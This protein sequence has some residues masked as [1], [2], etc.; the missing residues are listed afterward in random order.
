[1]LL[2][3]TAAAPLLQAMQQPGGATLLATA[4]LIALWVSTALAYPAIYRATSHLV[5]RVILD[6]G[7]YTSV[8]GDVALATSRAQN[9]DDACQQTCA[10]LARA[11]GVTREGVA[12]RLVPD[13][14]PPAHA[15]VLFPS[16][17]RDRAQLL[18]PTA[19]RPFVALE[20]APLP[21]SR[22]LLSD[23]VALLEGVGGVLG[24]RLDVL[25]V[26][27]ERFARDLREREILQLAAE[28]ELLALRAQLNPHFLFN[29]L[30]TLGYLMRADADR[31]L[32]VLYRLTA[33]LR[34][35]LRGPARSSVP[36]GE[37][38]DIVADYLAIERERFLERLS[39]TIDVPPALRE[40]QV[41]PILLQPLVENAVKHGIS[42]LRRGGE[43]RVSARC[44]AVLDDGTAMLTLQV[45]DTGAGWREEGRRTPS[46]TG[47]GLANLERRLERIFGGAA[48]LA[49]A[50]APD[51]GTTVTI[52]LPVDATPLE[53][54]V[55][56]A[57][58]S[59]GEGSRPGERPA[60]DLH[61]RSAG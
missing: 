14:N 5:D 26:A 9:E 38:L 48:T 25:R 37:E 27:R 61:A 30:T 59:L 15:R 54:D 10:I 20:I 3:L 7:D 11:L 42:P 47:V 55:P 6:R 33:L 36:L 19:E 51:R 52:T 31:A 28:S 18:V 16:P 44:E 34:A 45:A 57:E 53:G 56:P 35:V 24:R 23:E 49:I 41:P 46:G 12:W 39:V 40:L 2:H 22:R 17:E 32:R 21:E 8:R 43:V 60:H 4:A 13:G 1:V 50:G 58:P 29:A